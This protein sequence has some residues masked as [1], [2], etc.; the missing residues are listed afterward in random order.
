MNQ[1]A[2]RILE[3]IYTCQSDGWTPTVREIAKAVELSSPSTVH[4]HL[5]KLEANGYL[6][7]QSDKSRSVELTPLGLESVGAKENHG[8]P[9]IGTVTAGL[10]ITAVEELTD[11]FPLPPQLE[12]E[13]QPLFM[14]QIQGD[15]MINS[16]I[17]DRDWVIVRKQN[18]AENGEIVIAMTS[19]N[20]ATC[21]RFFKE[22]DHFRLQPEN[23]DFSPIILSE[24][25]ILGIVVGLYRHL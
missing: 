25:T 23:D 4:T 13:S 17:Y 10:P 6:K 20:E 15:S 19:D 1:R 22:S 11:F 9:M 18:T 14:L 16:G 7:H 3:Y 24:V 12:N 2:Q 21:K 5:K 8:I